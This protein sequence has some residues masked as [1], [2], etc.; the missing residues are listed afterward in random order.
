MTEAPVTQ[1]PVTQI[2]VTRAPITQTP[3]T[4]APVTQAP[5]TQEPITQPPVSLDYCIKITTG[6]SS[7]NNGYIKVLINSQ[8]AVA[9][10]KFAKGSIVLDQCYTSSPRVE[11]TSSHTDA[12]AGSFEYS[13]DGGSTYDY[14]VC[15]GCV[16]GTGPSL[17]IA[18]E[19]DS[20]FGS[21]AANG[22][23]NGNTCLIVPGNPFYYDALL[24]R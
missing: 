12:W 24:T 8:V 11:I 9:Q 5:V 19:A 15:E 14:M 20:N 22:C 10:Q 21:N 7:S 17:K 6:I 1:A 18:V 3:V 23:I 4:Q 16:T 2:P 13:E